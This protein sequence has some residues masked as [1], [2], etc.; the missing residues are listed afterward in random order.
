MSTMDAPSASNWACPRPGLGVWPVWYRNLLVWR[1]LL[2]ASLLLN[3][4]EPLLFLLGLGVGLG[5]FVGDMQG[6][7]YLTF[8]ASGILASSAMNAAS[9]EALFSVYTRMVPQQT[10]DGMLATPLGVD[11]IMGG[12]LLWCASKATLSCTAILLVAFALGAFS[13]PL[14][15]LCVPLF[16]L[17]GMSF[18]GLALVVCARAPGYDFF[19]Y[20]TTLVMTPMFLFCGVLYPIETL[21]DW[22][23]RIAQAL[24]LT[25]AVALLRPLAAGTWP[26]DAALH[27]GVLSA[28]AGIGFYVAVA[29]VRRR[30][31]Y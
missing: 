19:S 24:P 26:A 8:V 25:H 29:A 2:V 30:L 10:Y 4:G 17:A 5:R 7:P 15:L 11:D 12:E 31:I 22:L 9:F 1:K 23:Q 16:F 13:S 21:P 20:Y 3:F 28:Y 18:A 6:M 14:A 27:A